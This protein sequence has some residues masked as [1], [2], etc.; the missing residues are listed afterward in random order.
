MELVKDATQGGHK[1]LIFSSYTSMFD[2]IEEKLKKDNISY[3]KLTGQTKVE[4]RVDLVEDFNK[5]HR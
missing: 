1:I 5:I 2:K 3:Y 4:E